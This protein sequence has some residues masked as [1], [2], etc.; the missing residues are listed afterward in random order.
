MD[1]TQLPS[2]PLSIRGP[3]LRKEAAK[4]ISQV[5]MAA[6]NGVD[7]ADMVAGL[8]AFFNACISAA[9]AAAASANTD[10]GDPDDANP[11]YG[12]PDDANPDYGDPDQPESAPAPKATLKGKGK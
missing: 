7:V 3:V 11:D 10:Y 8:D 9:A 6:R 12:D 2:L 5:Q 4:V 1:Y